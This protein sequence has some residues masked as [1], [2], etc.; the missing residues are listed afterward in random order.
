MKL[1]RVLPCL[2][3]ENSSA[4]ICLTLATDCNNESHF[5]RLTAAFEDPSIR[6]LGM[7]VDRIR[8]GL[9]R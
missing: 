4:L 5:R 1:A 6:P 3:T 2:A 9:L 8:K 7:D